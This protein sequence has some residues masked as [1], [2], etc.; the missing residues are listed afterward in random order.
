[1]W[2]ATDYFSSPTQLK[3]VTTGVPDPSEMAY[4]SGQSHLDQSLNELVD[5]TDP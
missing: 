1:M 4:M 3:K 2:L 5:E